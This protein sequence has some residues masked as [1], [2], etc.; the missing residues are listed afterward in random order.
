M[1]LIKSLAAGFM[2]GLAGAV[3]V[4]ASSQAAGA[5]LFTVAL[6]AVLEMRLILFTGRCGYALTKCCRPDRLLAILALNVVGAAVM[7]AIYYMG[8]GPAEKMLSLVQAKAGQSALNT[9]GRAI[10]CGVLMFVAV[11]G[12]K[13]SES[14]IG[15]YLAMMLAV[16]AFVVAGFEHS[17]ADAFYM[18]VGV[19]GGA[20]GLVK[21]L[22]F[23]ALAAVGNVIGALAAYLWTY[24]KTK[25]N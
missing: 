24:V 15:R 23:V 21:A 14:P 7:A 19:L 11:D 13:K 9:I 25:E 1:F 3:Y 18:G 16:P 22:V 20:V 12:Y 17:I 8:F 2:V 6:F 5:V 10:P 4:G